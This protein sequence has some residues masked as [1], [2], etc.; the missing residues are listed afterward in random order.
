LKEIIE[1][2]QL[3]Y[4]EFSE[5]SGLNPRFKPGSKKLK[6]VLDVSAPKTEVGNADLASFFVKLVKLLPSLE[7]HQ[8]G[9]HLFE[10]IRSGSLTR[11][12]QQ[13][14][15]TTNIAHMMEH[16]IIDLQSNITSMNSC[17]G[18]TCGYK[19]PAFRFD[20]FVECKDKK[21]GM[22]SAFFAAE[23]LR[24]L[25]TDKG[26]SRRYPNLIDLTK[27]LYRKGSHQRHVEPDLLASQINQKFGWRKSYVLL[28]LKKLKE[29]G[30]LG[31]Q[32]Q[33]INQNLHR[34]RLNE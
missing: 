6:V 21:V 12:Q 3:S 27:H 33:P 8:C 31:Y 11:D 34:R 19:E 16:V 29:F 30:F 25:V 1:I 26:L 10:D 20:L 32:N 23:V 28:L 5:V 18:I 2:R 14:D 22:F 13:S 24:R 9:E 4:G 15:H 17:S 7:R